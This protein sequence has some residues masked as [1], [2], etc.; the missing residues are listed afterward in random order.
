M[1]AN[2]GTR[3]EGNLVAGLEEDLEARLDQRVVPHPRSS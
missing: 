1:E 2:L 3:L